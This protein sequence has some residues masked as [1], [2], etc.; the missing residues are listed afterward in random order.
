M[1][2]EIILDY[3][4]LARRLRDERAAGRTLAVTNGCFEL[5]HVGHVSLIAEARGLAD[6]LV[7]A[8][9]GD[10][11]VRRNK[12]PDRPMVRLAERARVIGALEG[13]RYV[14]SFDEPTA[15]LL[16]AALAPDVHVKGTDWRAEHVPEREVVE[17][18][19]GRVVICG[20]AKTRSSSAL[21]ERLQGTGGPRESGNPGPGSV[22]RDAVNDA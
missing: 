18:G 7:V 11:S 4:E 9:N 8:L 2:A 19:G 17:R 10:A 12:G 13:V 22:A 15:H 16:L 3:R 1:T 5:L 20:E 6:I 21:I 14:T